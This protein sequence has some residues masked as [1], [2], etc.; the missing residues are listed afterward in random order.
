[1]NE[2]VLDFLL[3]NAKIEEVA[4]PAESSVNPS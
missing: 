3:Q 4:A 1:M 2:K